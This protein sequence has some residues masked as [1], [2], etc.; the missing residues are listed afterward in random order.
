MNGDDAGQFKSD[1]AEL[2]RRLVWVDWSE[3]GVWEPTADLGQFIISDVKPELWASAQKD[4]DLLRTHYWQR[5]CD[6]SATDFANHYTFEQCWESYC[7]AP[8][9][10]WVWLLS[11]MASFGSD[12]VPDALIQYFH[13]QLLTFIESHGDREWY[14]LKP[15]VCLLP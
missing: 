13:D 12:R 3:V 9:E 2:L 11:V 7:R 5:L 15:I 1:Y 10:R 14:S 8:V 6:L 4:R